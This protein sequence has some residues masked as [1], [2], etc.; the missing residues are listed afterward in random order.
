MSAQIR[1]QNLLLQNPDSNII[2]V[3][4]DNKIKITGIKSFSNAKLVAVGM[5]ISS[6]KN[7]TFILRATTTGISS[8]TLYDGSR[9][10]ATK[11][12]NVNRIPEPIVGLGAF[13][14]T[15]LS[16]SQIMENRKLVSIIPN[17]IALLK[18]PVVKFSNTIVSQKD[19]LYSDFRSSGDSLSEGLIKII[20]NLKTGDKII[21]ESIQVQGPDDARIAPFYIILK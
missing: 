19:T 1:F 12:Y 21:F 8:L 16:I 20:S 7:G 10:V 6:P 18:Y 9:L 2:Y 14:D 3:G 15:T 17:C 13:R 5:I 4:L 11:Q